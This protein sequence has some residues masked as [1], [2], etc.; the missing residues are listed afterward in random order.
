KVWPA[1]DELVKHDVA[2]FLALSEE[3]AKLFANVLEKSRALDLEAHAALEQLGAA[4][5]KPLPEKKDEPSAAHRALLLYRAGRVQDAYAL[6]D[7]LSP[8]ETRLLERLRDVRVHDY[9]DHMLADKTPLAKGVR[10]KAEERSQVEITNKYRQMM[11]REA[12]EIHPCLLDAARGHSH[13]MTELGYFAHESP[14]ER[15]RTPGDRVRNAGYEYGPGENISLGSVGPQATHDAWYNSSGHH[16]NI[17]GASWKAMGAGLD[18]Q[19]WT[20]D[21]GPVGLL[22]R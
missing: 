18:G 2:G 22:E 16:R 17:L 6:A 11:G 9:N 4:N 14:V 8:W 20:Q 3:Q 21:Y 12:L 5:L 10:P 7:Q 1:F 13:E 15:N 19:H